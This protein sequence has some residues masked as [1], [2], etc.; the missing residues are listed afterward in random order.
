MRSSSLILAEAALRLGSIRLAARETRQ[1]ASTCSLALRRLEEALAVTLARRNT[2]G[3]ALTL[4]GRRALPLLGR[5]AAGLRALHAHPG[6]T[7]PER[8]LALETLFRTAEALRRGSIR[9]AA[10]ALGL[11]QPQL[12]R[13]VA[14][15]EAVLGVS[16]A[17][18]DDAGLTA[19]AAGQTFETRVSA[20]E[21]DWQALRNP[22]RAPA[23]A[24]RLRPV[25]LGSVI[26]ATP[27]GALSQMLGGLIRRLRE[28][29]ALPFSLVSTL[30][31]D[32]LSGLD[33]GRFDCVFLDARLDD[34]YYNQVELQRSPV[35]LCG[36]PAT[37]APGDA[38]PDRAKLRALLESHPLVLQ[39]RR[40]GLRQRA[41]AFWEAQLGADWRSAAQIVEI[42]SLPIIVNVLVAG[43]YLSVLPQHV[44][45]DFFSDRHIL[46]PP[47][48]DQ[49]LMLTW[50]NT[51][52]PRRIVALI[53][54]ELQNAAAP[55]CTAQE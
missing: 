4:E 52:K 16:L 18:R 45:Q 20:L 39:S 37:S 8:A 7:V 35:A 36:L 49:R 1:P 24:R 38:M 40:S 6:P 10:R 30:A 53:A 17:L 51:G 15:V 23:P 19:S 25:S 34:R 44:A 50:R 29:H 54:Q 3:L 42:D 13:Q 22:G 31:E 46:L 2:D 26:P 43:G 41:E 21:A 12:S 33:S 48:Y 11:G 28:G 55:D 5:L 9:S 32:L 27:D 47:R 14:M